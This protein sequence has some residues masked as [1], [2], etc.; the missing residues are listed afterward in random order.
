[1]KGAGC[2]PIILQIR[3]RGL[4]EGREKVFQE[5]SVASDRIPT[6]T[7]LR[8]MTG[9]MYWLINHS[10]DESGFRDVWNQILKHRLMSASLSDH[11]LH[12]VGDLAVSSFMLQSLQFCKQRQKS[13]SWKQAPE[14]HPSDPIWD[15]CSPLGTSLSGDGS[16]RLE[17]ERVS[18]TRGLSQL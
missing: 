6:Q 17:E 2:S 1:M 15:P 13:C 5:S 14:K 16:S 9:M 7:N 11:F 8:K 12:E 18:Q 10:K 3:R 4:R